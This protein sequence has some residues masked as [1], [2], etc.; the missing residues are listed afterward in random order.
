[1]SFTWLVFFIRKR[2]I[3]LVVAAFLGLI[4]G[5]VIEIVLPPT[6]KSTLSIKQNYETGENLYESIK[7]YNGLIK[8]KDFKVLGTILGLSASAS[9]EIVKF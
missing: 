9:Q 7:Y 6:Y 2:L 3:V 1:M 5:V 8:D 4:T